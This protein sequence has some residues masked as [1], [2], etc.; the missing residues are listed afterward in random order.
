MKASALCPGLRPQL[1][2]HRSIHSKLPPLPR[3]KAKIYTSQIWKS[4]SPQTVSCERPITIRAPVK[5]LTPSIARGQTSPLPMAEGT[6]LL[7]VMVGLIS[8]EFSRDLTSINQ[9]VGKSTLLRHIAMREVPIPPHIT[10]L[11]VEQ[12]VEI[13]VLPLATRLYDLLD[14]WR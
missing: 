14:R 3:T 9:G 6:V 7:V 4:T 13:F 5:Y 10:I 11:F 2:A 1:M 8:G 12:E